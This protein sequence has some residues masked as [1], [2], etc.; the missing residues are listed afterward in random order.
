MPEDWPRTWPRTGVPRSARTIQAPLIC[1][2]RARRWRAGHV[3]WV[4][5]PTQDSTGIERREARVTSVCALA[6]EPNWHGAG[7]TEC[8]SRQLADSAEAV[9]A[10]EVE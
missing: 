8:N 2:S 6:R 10:G 3:C 7:L 9:H 1:L 5:W 4:R